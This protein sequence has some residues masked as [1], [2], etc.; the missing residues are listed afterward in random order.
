MGWDVEY[1]DE[2]GAWWESRSDDQQERIVALVGLLEERGPTLGR[3]Y[4]DTLSG[5]SIPNLKEL[6]VPT[7]D[8]GV[9]RILFAFD[10]LRVA[11]LLLGGD[12]TG[13]WNDWYKWAIAEAERLY[14]GHLVQL[15]R[16]GLL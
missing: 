8:E 13:A 7:T 12:K 15:R 6:R 10:L 1:T 4:T 11:I 16:E 3:P 9:L 14:E 2:F 5:S